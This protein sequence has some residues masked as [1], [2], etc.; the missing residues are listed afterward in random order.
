VLAVPL[1]N[2]PWARPALAY[3]AVVAALWPFPVFGLLHAESGAVVAAAAYFVSS[4]AAVGALRRGEP[5][6]PVARRSLALLAVPLAG[7]TLSLLWRANCAYGTGLGLFAVLVP[8]SAVLG[9]GVAAA[10]VAAR[11]RRPRVWAVV[12]GLAVVV[13]G[14][15]WDLGFHPQLFTYNAVFGGVLGPIYDEELSVRPGLF[16]AR[17]TTLLWA[18]LLFC[19]AR[20]KGGGG[21]RP[22][23]VGGMLALA[24][25][26]ATAFSVPLGVQQSTAGIERVLSLRASAGRVVLHLSPETRAADVRRLSDEAAFRLVQIEGRLGVRAS[27]PVHV[28]LYPD[29]ETKGRLTGSR[30]TSVVPVWLARPQVHMLEA[31]VGQS[32]GHELAHVV[33]REF[34]MPVL[35]ASPAVGLVEGLAVAV[36]PPDGLPGAEALVAAGLTL[37]GDAGG[38]DADPAAVVRQAMT[39]LGFWGGRAAVAYTATGAFVGYAMETCG[40]PAVREA[41]RTGDVSRATGLPLDTLTAR[42]AVHLRTVPVTAEARATAAWLFREPSLFEVRCPH[43]VPEYVRKTRAGY[44]SLDAGRP[45][46]AADLFAEALLG[47]PRY[48]PALAGW[49]AAFAAGGAR[50]PGQIMRAVE[51]VSRDTSASALALRALA[52]H[53]RL[54]ERD[55]FASTLYARAGARLVPTDRVGRLALRLRSGLSAEALRRLFSHPGGPARAAAEA[56]RLAPF[57]AALLW[58]EAGEPARAWAS[59]RRTPQGGLAPDERAA[60]RLVA[61]QLAYRAGDIEAAGRLAARAER[62]LRAAGADALARVAADWRE[63][64]RWRA[65]QGVPGPGSLP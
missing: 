20:W 10:L 53:A 5:V 59:V 30:Q 58:S 3:A 31:A 25:G 43:H 47:G 37:S 52:D 57:H 7:L 13:G 4:V 45:E 24:L 11:V 61:A 9:V 35:K 32:L 51:V 41:Y 38:L 44:D 55:R 15:V 49:V 21:R 64:V 50:S 28:Y 40:V 6:G 12:V 17:A 14:T 39:P 54:T 26:A 2:R 18:A 36:E 60:L 56:E 27:G 33:A 48:A 63:R 46:A 65:V 42:W 16:A 1:L 29:E 19:W 23:Q 8:P 62:D 34:G 22:A